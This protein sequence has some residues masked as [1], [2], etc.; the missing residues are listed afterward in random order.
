M[1]EKFWK[2]GITQPVNSPSEFIP[3]TGTSPQNSPSEFIPFTN[4]PSQPQPISC[5]INLMS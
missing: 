4:L 3:K 1:G 2:T 5:T